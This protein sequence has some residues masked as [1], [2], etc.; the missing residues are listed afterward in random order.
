MITAATETLQKDDE[1]EV[2][3]QLL[4]VGDHALVTVTE[5]GGD[6]Y[7]TMWATVVVIEPVILDDE[8]LPHTLDELAMLKEQ[9]Q[10]EPEE[11]PEEEP[12]KPKAKG[13]RRAKRQLELVPDE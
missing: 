13:G 9:A 6:G 7:D 10:R 1:N 2:F 5:T 8:G 3:R 4:H 11:E 12:E